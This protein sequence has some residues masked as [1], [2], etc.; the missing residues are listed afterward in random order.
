MTFGAL[1]LVMAGV[2]FV[3]SALPAR[4]ATRVDPMVTLRSE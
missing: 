2:S 1:T 4:S 3:A